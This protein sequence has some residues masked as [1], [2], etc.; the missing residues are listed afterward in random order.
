MPLIA[1]VAGIMGVGAAVFVHSVFFGAPFLP[2]RT[3]YIQ[4]SLDMLGL[5]PGQHLLE[6]G[7]GDGRVL[8][9]AARR[10]IYST[11]YEI[12]PILYIYSWLRT[13]R[14]RKYVTLVRGNYWLGTL[15]S[16]DG[17]Y[18]F[19]LQPYMRRLDDKL[20]REVTV[21]TKLLSFAF[22]VPGKKPIATAEGIYMYQY[23]PRK[24]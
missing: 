8:V 4:Q 10:G 11:G 24:S 9:A 22:Y 3:R 6:L 19:L 17:I 16:A 21:P 1:V 23:L 7:S 15:P 13:W 20:S 18:V 5:Q 12:N 2:A 14:Y